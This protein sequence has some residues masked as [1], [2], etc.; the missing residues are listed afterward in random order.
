MEQENFEDIDDKEIKELQEYFDK[1]VWSQM[2]KEV[3][4][5]TKKESCFF[6]FLAGSQ[7]MKSMNDMQHENLEGELKNMEEKMKGMSGDEIKKMLEKDKKERF[8]KETG[9]LIKAFSLSVPSEE[10]IKI[11][12]EVGFFQAIKSVIV[13]T[14]SI[15]TKTGEEYD[16]AI[17]Q[18]LS[19]A[20]ISDRIVDIFEAVGIEKPNI[21]VLSEKFLLE[22]KGMKEK[23]LAFESLKKLLND[24][25][26]IRMKKN[27]VMS[28]SF[29][30]MLE[31]TIKRYTNN[32]IDAAEAIEELI[33]TARGIKED[34]EIGKKLNLKEDEK[35]F[36][37]ALASNQSAI[38]VLG[39][40]TLREIALEIVRLIKNSVKVD[41]TI[42]ESVQAELKLKVKLVLRRYKYPPDQEESATN[43]VLE[44]AQVV[45][46]DWAEKD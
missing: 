3:R 11:R 17:R 39:N 26:K 4:E 12:E 31:K 10:A 7:M 45:A 44:Q 38:E 22:V 27:V 42:R 46:K 14:I 36:Y 2:K 16:S 34:I 30:E 15:K 13:K 23:N 1:E 20:V 33:R 21:S 19:K 29:M 18:I 8:V 25:I 24:E 43:L 28:K 5:M 41:W 40:D 35:A 6:A 32:T 37:D 9:L